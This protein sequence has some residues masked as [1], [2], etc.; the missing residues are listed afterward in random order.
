[1]AAPPPNYHLFSGTDL[2][3]LGPRPAQDVVFQVLIPWSQKWPLCSSRPRAWSCCFTPPPACHVALP[4]G[5]GQAAPCIEPGW[6]CLG[7][8]KRTQEGGQLT[9]WVTYWGWACTGG[10]EELGWTLPT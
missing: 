1:M 4:T 8:N 10:L 9:N 2:V 6:P 5:W 3:G 7:W